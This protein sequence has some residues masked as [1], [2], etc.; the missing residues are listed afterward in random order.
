MEPLSDVPREPEHLTTTPSTVRKPPPIYIDYPPSEVN[1]TSIRKW[2]TGLKVSASFRRFNDQ[3]Y[4]IFPSDD[5]TSRTLQTHC[6]QLAIP[7]Y[8]YAPRHIK[9]HGQY[10]IL[11]LDINQPTIPE[12][13]EALTNVPDITNIRHMTK[14]DCNGLKHPINPVVVTTLS[15]TTLNHFKN[16]TDIC[17]YRVKIVKYTPSQTISQCTNCQQFGHTKNYCKRKPICVRCSGNH[18]IVECDR[19]KSTIKCSGCGGD[20]VASYRQ[21]PARIKLL[22]EKDAKKENKFAARQDSQ[23]KTGNKTPS[24]P[25]FAD[26]PPLPRRQNPIPGF[27]KRTP[28]HNPT[29]NCDPFSTSGF[30]ELLSKFFQHFTSILIQHIETTFKSMCSAF[31]FQK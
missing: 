29:P 12:I 3:Q 24:T 30:T 5:L 13:Q 6:T 10:L 14:S 26:F 17:Y 28:I 25:Q 18:D 9:K 7:Y 31:M 15:T 21:C 11:G 20:H 27:G 23:S 2:L 1:S 19:Q 16:I 4:I 22:K 8:T